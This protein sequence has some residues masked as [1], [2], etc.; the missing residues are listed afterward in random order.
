MYFVEDMIVSKSNH[1]EGGEW[2]WWRSR[3]LKDGQDRQ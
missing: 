2:I 3:G 1:K